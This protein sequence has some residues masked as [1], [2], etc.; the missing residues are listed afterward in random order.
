[1]SNAAPQAVI[2]AAIWTAMVL[3]SPARAGEG[4]VRGGDHEELTLTRYYASVQLSKTHQLSNKTLVRKPSFFFSQA[5]LTLHPVPEKG[6]YR[7]KLADVAARPSRKEAVSFGDLTY[8]CEEMLDPRTTMIYRTKEVVIASQVFDLAFLV[9]EGVLKNVKDGKAFTKELKCY[10]SGVP[11]AVKSLI[12]TGKI[13]YS[14]PQ[15]VLFNGVEALEVQITFSVDFTRVVRKALGAGKPAGFAW[16][17]KYEGTAVL[18]CDKTP[19]HRAL[20]FDGTIAKSS[21][22]SEKGQVPIEET[23]VKRVLFKRLDAPKPVA[24]DAATKLGAADSAAPLG[25]P[26]PSSVRRK[27]GP[28]FEGKSGPEGKSPNRRD[29]TTAFVCP[30]HRHIGSSKK[31]KCPI[32]GMTMVRR[33]E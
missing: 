33:E 15:E 31:V 26:R 32:C 21:K 11:V 16:K 25:K 13:K 22:E 24:G 3:P 20:M 8:L 17:L 29:A 12:E 5:V 28:E 10:P 6:R 2:F 18:V 19:S 30:L 1:M 7:C 27:E 4:T 23:A 9:D 14:K